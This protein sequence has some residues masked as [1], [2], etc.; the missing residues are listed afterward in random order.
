MKGQR[1]LDDVRPR[2][3]LLTACLLLAHLPGCRSDP[4]PAPAPRSFPERIAQAHGIDAW[5]NQEGLTG[6]LLL[7][8]EGQPPL[9]LR[10]AH[11]VHGGRARMETADGTVL[12]WDGRHAWVSPSASPMP[13]A[14]FHLLSWPYFLA[15]PFKLGDPGVQLGEPAAGTL[16]G[17]SYS[18]S[19]MTFAP[20]TGDAPDDWYVVYADPQ[21]HRLEALAYIVTYG[22]SKA[23]AE[24]DPHAI[25]YHD[26]QRVD[27]VLVP[28]EWRFWSWNASAG[29]H[30]Q[31][32]GRGV[33]SNL[34]FAPLEPNAF[35]RPQDAR[36]DPLPPRQ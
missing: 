14:R 12:V 16:R 8:F 30:G 26:F 15:V 32:L 19:R 28:H 10:F 1:D 4:Q 11:E 36:E 13:M 21:T 31:P 27:G 24:E 18:T 2:A 5:R 25:T 29:I 34:D 6:R 33:L 9:E 23:K 35:A 17:K 20:G 7:A 22:Q 3:V